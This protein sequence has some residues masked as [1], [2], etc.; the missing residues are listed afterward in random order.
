[1]DFEQEIARPV[2]VTV[3]ED[4]GHGL[5]HRYDQVADGLG[6]PAQ[7]KGRLFHE[8]T[9][10]LQVGHACQFVL[11][12]QHQVHFILSCKGSYSVSAMMMN[13]HEHV[14][15]RDGQCA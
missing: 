7:R 12:A 10:R 8:A 2:F 4:I 5:I 3:K 1:M 15:A 9:N 14:I 13:V 6:L 11:A